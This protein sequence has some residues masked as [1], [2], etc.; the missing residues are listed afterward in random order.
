MENYWCF[1][2]VL[3]VVILSNELKGE[4]DYDQI[5]Q[6]SSQLDNLKDKFVQLYCGVPHLKG[7]W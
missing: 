7:R 2:H 1:F 3:K 6:L 5:V 4:Q